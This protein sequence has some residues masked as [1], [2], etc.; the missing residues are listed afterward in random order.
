MDHCQYF[1]LLAEASSVT[2]RRKAKAKGHSGHKAN[3]MISFSSPKGNCCFAN[4]PI[5]GRQVQHD[6][7]PRIEGAEAQSTFGPT[8]TG[9]VSFCDRSRGR[10]Q[11]LKLK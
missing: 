8:G 5:H 9:M 11:T 4:I 1:L 10:D 2:G 3:P 6:E 7:T